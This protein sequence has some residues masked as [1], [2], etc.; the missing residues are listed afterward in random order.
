MSG[1]ATLPK[2]ELHCHIEGA[3]APA[4]AH[5]IAGRNGITLPASLFTAQGGYAWRNFGEF[6]AAYDA[7]A[8]A[9]RTAQDYTELMYGYLAG[10][11]AEGAIYVGMFTSPDQAIAI[12]LGHAAQIAALA[13]GIDHAEAEFGIVS[14]LIP[15]C[16]RHLGPDRA[17]EVA[18]LV[19]AEPHRCVVGFGMAGDELQHT[20]ADFRPSASPTAPAWPAPCTPARWP[21][22]TACATP[23][24]RCRSAASAMACARSRIPLWSGSW[25]DAASS[26]RSAPAATWPWGS[27]AMP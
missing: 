5:A 6:L 25:R 7:A 22:R 12:G 10:C 23:S 15:C 18:R 16:L 27:I 21:A 14:R 2:A 20:P 19:A 9:M 1:I 4:L 24:P 13:A 11:A 8:G 26:W 3:M 17:L